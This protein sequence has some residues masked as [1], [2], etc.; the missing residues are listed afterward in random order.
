MQEGA[1]TNNGNY[2]TEILKPTGE[3]E[4]VKDAAQFELTASD[5]TEPE[6]P[7]GIKL[8][9]V[10]FN[11]VVWYASS[12][13]LQ[14]CALP[15]TWGKVY[16]FCSIKWTYLVSLLIFEVG[17]VIAGAAPNSTALIIGRAISGI[18]TGGIGTGAYNLIAIAVPSHQR[19]TLIGLVGGMYGF[20]SIAGPLMGGAFTDNKHLTWRWCF[21]IN[22]PLG[23]I[24]A[25]FIFLPPGII[26]SYSEHCRTINIL[27]RRLRSSLFE[28]TR[29]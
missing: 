15:L 22:L 6:Y 16:T 8:V 10:V 11:D 23:A 7:K 24:T 20:A 27:F 4:F 18:G 12:Y 5:S 13:I 9:L 2:E 3:K 26:A 21:Y 28:I 17:S 14:F 19:P 29:T 25:A 1:E